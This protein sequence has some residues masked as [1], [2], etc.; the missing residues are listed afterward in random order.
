[1]GGTCHGNPYREVRW[2]APHLGG[3]AF[4]SGRPALIRER[5]RTCTM[6][7][8]TKATC[9]RLCPSSPPLWPPEKATEGKRKL[10]I[11][12]LSIRLCPPDGAI[13]RA[14]RCH[15]GPGTIRK[16]TISGQIRGR[17]GG[18]FYRATPV[19]TDNLNTHRNREDSLRPRS[20]DTLWQEL[21]CDPPK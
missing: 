5:V 16:S 20:H 17:S 15:V 7:S 14:F 21:A 8:R 3:L 12:G 9:F 13:P 18:H 2:V 11:K 6:T 4:T 19:A 10:K 1:M